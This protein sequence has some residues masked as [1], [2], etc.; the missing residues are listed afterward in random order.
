MANKFSKKF[1][2]T[3]QKTANLHILRESK[4]PTILLELGFIN[5]PS[6]RNYLAS[7]KGQTETAEKILSFINEN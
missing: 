7:E 5:N 4:T 3:V 1:Q 6:E 2:N